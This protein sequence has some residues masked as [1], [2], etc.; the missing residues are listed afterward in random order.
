MCLH[1]TDDPVS[2][3][4]CNALARFF[5]CCSLLTPR[6][7]LFICLLFAA[8][9]ACPLRPNCLHGLGY[10]RPQ[11]GSIWSAH[12]S[13]LSS[14]G[15][16]P[17]ASKRGEGRGHA[18]L[19]N[20]GALCYLNTLFQTLFMN[21]HFRRGIYKFRSKVQRDEA[22]AGAKKG[23]KKE[24]DS[25][26]VQPQ[27]SKMDVEAAMDVKQSDQVEDDADAIVSELQSL[28]ARLE[29]GKASFEDPCRIV[30]KLKLSRG[31]Q[32]DVNEFNNLF[33]QHLEAR[34]KL[35]EIPG[36]ATLIEDEFRGSITHAV[37]CSRCGTVSQKPSP[38]YDITLQIH[39]MK[40]VQQAML[41][42]MQKEHLEGGNQY[43]CGKC[44][45]PQNAVRSTVITQ[46]P[47]VLNLQLLRFA[48]DAQSD[49]KKKLT[50]NISIPAR[51][52][53]AP[54]KSEESIEIMTQQQVIDLAEKK[55]GGSGEGAAAAVA[56]GSAARPVSPAV[57]KTGAPPGA[58]SSPAMRG[59]SSSSTSSASSDVY[60]LTA[61]LR[62]KG[63]SAYHGHYVADI[64]DPQDPQKWWRFD[65]DKCTPLAA[66]D[67]GNGAAKPAEGDD[68]KK[69]GKKGKAKKGAKKPKSGA[70]S[71]S[72][73]D[74][75]EEDDDF[76]VEG[77]GAAAAK[78]KD[79]DVVILD[80][81][82]KSV[83]VAPASPIVIDADE[84]EE[85]SKGGEKKKLVPSLAKSVCR[86]C[87]IASSHS[88]ACAHFLSCVVFLFLCSISSRNAYMLVYTRVGRP[89]A[90][91]ITR[92]DLTPAMETQIHESDEGLK[93][94]VAEWIDRKEQLEKLI[95]GRKTKCE[96]VWNLAQASEIV[97]G[98]LAAAC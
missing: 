50:D 24:D 86:S 69:T 88:V 44:K 52:D 83:A 3:A 74:D 82:D 43:R 14:L 97:R 37:T 70:A 1:A 64:R 66:L 60:E 90:P 25:E 46:L 62:H 22:A 68:K 59:S 75:D 71:G 20:L 39:R 10:R 19:K 95:E 31:E 2:F 76:D 35:T 54:F 33:L 94:R 13:H 65:D 48:Y 63:T 53:M 92:A 21:E 93:K 96:Q 8:K 40:T 67:D 79:D 38:F 16:D 4:A 55:N 51:I 72:D 87:S 61:I 9:K 80:D 78:A 41:A 36:V 29:F 42:A 30:S 5:A 91:V 23:L 85:K 32:Q 56:A 34:L 18:G 84:T 89:A 77:D 26:S 81:D 73:E 7:L 45:S 12:P 28:F 17:S 6:L 27:E 49:S 11:N 15:P 98:K 58:P 47:P 57:R